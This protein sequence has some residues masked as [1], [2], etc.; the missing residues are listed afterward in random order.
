MGVLLKWYLENKKK[1][2][3]FVLATVFHHKFEKIHPFMDGNGRTGRMLFNY[4]LLKN[5]Y[6]PGIIRRKNRNAY[7]NALQQ[8]DKSNLTETSKKDYE[9]LVQF[10]ANELTENYWNIFL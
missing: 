4:I 7:I 6:P 9:K 2:H 5:Q 1:F 10:T 8:A 3:P